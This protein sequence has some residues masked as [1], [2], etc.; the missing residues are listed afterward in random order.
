M[1]TE[2]HQRLLDQLTDSDWVQVF[3]LRPDLAERIRNI[4]PAGQT[5]KGAVNDQ[6]VSKSH[7]VS[8]YVF[9]RPIP[10]RL[11][12][13]Y[14]H[15][16]LGLTHIRLADNT[17]AN[18]VRAAAIERDN[19]IALD[20]AKDKESEK[21]LGNLVLLSSIVRIGREGTDKASV[22]FLP[23]ESYLRVIAAQED[24]QEPSQPSATPGNC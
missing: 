2:N 5:I 11:I 7:E 12:N 10:S 17:S 3:A 6:D 4:L 22:F 21:P 20:Y 8:D 14:L 13:Y 9:G 23:R 15:H 18:E 1:I 24:V 19:A 16:S